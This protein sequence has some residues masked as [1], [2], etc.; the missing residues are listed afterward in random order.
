MTDRQH[1]RGHEGIQYD[2][3][4]GLKSKCVAHDDKDR[5]V[6]TWMRPMGVKVRSLCGK[7]HM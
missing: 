6:T 5:P 7:T 2:G 3:R 4:C 1:Q